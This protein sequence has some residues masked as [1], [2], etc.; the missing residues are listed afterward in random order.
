MAEYQC[1]IHAS[2]DTFWVAKKSSDVAG[3]YP[4]S[5]EELSDDF[6][7]PVAD[8]AP[9]EEDYQVEVET[10]LFVWASRIDPT[11]IVVPEE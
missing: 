1:L 11:L 6:R 3:R 8:A 7:R 10:G 2:D 4:W 5:D 9:S